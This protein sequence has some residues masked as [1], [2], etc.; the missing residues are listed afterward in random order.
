MWHN[1]WYSF[2]KTFPQPATTLTEK[3][4]LY[5]K[6]NHSKVPRKLGKWLPKK[7]YYGISGSLTILQPHYNI[8][9]W[10]IYYEQ[11]YIQPSVGKSFIPAVAAVHT[12]VM[13]LPSVIVSSTSAPKQGCRLEAKEK[14]PYRSN[15]IV[16]R[17]GS[18][19]CRTRRRSKF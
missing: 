12:L 14:N 15:G 7:L 19:T 16:K 9:S 11:V 5:L 4:R 2:Y 8:R 13:S 3:Y 18:K 10:H 1:C 17:R 6:H